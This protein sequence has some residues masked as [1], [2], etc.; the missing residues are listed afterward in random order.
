[1]LIDTTNISALGFKL[2]KLEKQLT[3]PRRKQVL[4]KPQHSSANLVYEEFDVKVTLF[5]RFGSTMALAAAVN[6][7]KS[8]L[9]ATTR[10]TFTIESRG[11]SFTGIVKNGFEAIPYDNKVLINMNITVTECQAGNLMV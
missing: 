5:G 9:K 6:N 3:L 4:A 8:L 10:H 11:L 1:M 7:L 2:M